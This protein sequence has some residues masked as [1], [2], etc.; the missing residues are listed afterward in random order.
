[1][2]VSAMQFDGGV[3]R[4]GCTQHGFRCEGGASAQETHDADHIAT[5]R[6]GD[7]SEHVSSQEVRRD[8]DG[9]NITPG[10][11]R[12]LEQTLNREP[13]SADLDRQ[14]ERNESHPKPCKGQDRAGA[15]E[16]PDCVAK[17]KE[18]TRNAE[19]KSEKGWSCNE[20]APR[21]STDEDRGACRS[22]VYS[23]WTGC[24]S[25]LATRAKRWSRV[26]R[27]APVRTQAAR[28]SASGG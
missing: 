13:L 26:T 10:D 15:G 5:T 12:T 9:R 11:S 3:G 19:Q 8:R 27:V 4:E 7:Q 21:R 6:S 22:H 16:D 14:A 24:E 2:R 28:W 23:S 18:S 20:Q 17:R 1:M 25:C